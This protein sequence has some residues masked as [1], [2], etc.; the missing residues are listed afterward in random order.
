MMPKMGPTEP[1]RS[2]TFCMV[3]NSREGPPRL[4]VGSKAK[5]PGMTHRPAIRATTVSMT[6]MTT[7][8]FWRFF[9]LSM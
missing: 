1:M 6:T 3:T 5:R 4:P 8:F 7:A 9:F 2:N